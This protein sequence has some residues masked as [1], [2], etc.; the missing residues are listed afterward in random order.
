MGI[1]QL[2]K[3]QTGIETVDRVLAEHVDKLN[4]ILRALP[5]PGAH[6]L[7]P[8]GAQQTGTIYMGTGVPGNPSGSNGDFYFRIDDPSVANHRIYVRI[9]GAW[10]GIL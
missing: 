2:P 3:P 10:T 8:G 6:P 4:P 5:A 1:K 7:T 9:A